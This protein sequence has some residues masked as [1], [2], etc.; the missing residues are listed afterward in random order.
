MPH[1]LT[2]DL[3]YFRERCEASLPLPAVCDAQV[4]L[5]RHKAAVVEAFLRCCCCWP[6]GETYVPLANSSPITIL[7]WI[8]APDCRTADEAAV[9]MTDRA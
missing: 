3:T 5:L 1:F 9:P 6:S 7:P 8:L 4:R 2:I